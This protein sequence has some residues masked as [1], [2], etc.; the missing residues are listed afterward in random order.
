[1]KKYALAVI[2]CVAS[3]CAVAQERDPLPMPTV[4]LDSL[5]KHVMELSSETYAGRLAGTKGCNEAENYV[6]KALQGY[7][8]KP[9]D[10]DWLQRFEVECNEVENAKL[11]VYM[12]GSK[13]K[14]VFT[15]GN[16][17]AC[18]GMTGR[19]YVD[20]QMVFCGYGIASPVFDEYENVD[21]KG[22]IVIVLTGLPQG[23]ALPQDVIEH[24]STLRD[25]A[26]VAEN[27]GAIG[28]LAVNVS[29]S[30]LSNEVQ[31]RT[32]CGVLPHLATFPLLQ[33]T[34]DGAREIM[35]DEAMALD[36]ARSVIE[37]HKK[38]AS[39]TL[40]KKAEID[41]NARYTPQAMT[42][43]V[44]G[45]LEGSDPKLRKEYIVVGASIDGVGMQGETCIFPGADI[46][47]S[48]VAALLETARVLSQREYRPKRSIV[49][50]VFSGSEQQYLGSQIFVSNF[51]PMRR[52]EAFVNVQNIGSGDS[53]VV[54]GDNKYPTLWNLAYVHDTTASRR[55]IRLD[56]GKMN[57]R[58]D[59]LAFDAV[60]IPTLVFTTYNGLQHNHVPS[61]IWE[62]VDVRIMGE[63]ARLVAEV[64]AELGEGLYQGRSPRSRAYRF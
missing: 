4:S 43:N 10:K 2:L 23:V 47:A 13:D 14:R 33:L 27:K 30:C 15:L 42:S 55:N 31:C 28:M 17:F 45:I 56:G 11:N 8:V 61:D 57:P 62:N 21:V 58:G 60:G 50:V 51:S 18:A 12:P 16:E 26:R 35:A 7:G 37:K 36:S 34:L 39:Y 52:I 38:V 40:L 53:I 48:G 3:V 24:G 1:M 9:Q 6:I 63:A 25:K 5:V 54:M 20:A 22:K 19:G 41:V 44:I 49:F 46:N 59:G 32:Y 29:E 64:V